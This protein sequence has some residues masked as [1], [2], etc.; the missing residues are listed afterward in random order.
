M[1]T[2]VWGGI[3][4]ATD[5]SFGC[6]GNI[7][8][9][10]FNECCGVNECKQTAAQLC[11]NSRWNVSILHWQKHLKQPGTQ[12]S[13]HYCKNPTVCNRRQ[14]S[15]KLI[16]TFYGWVFRCYTVIVSFLCCV[17]DVTH[18]AAEGQLWP[19]AK[20]R[21]V[22]QLRVCSDEQQTQWKGHY[23]IRAGNFLQLLKPAWGDEHVHDG[24]S[25]TRSTLQKE[26]ITST[27][28]LLSVSHIFFFLS[29]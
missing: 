19:R 22:V 15:K 29:V 11:G 27:S 14:V 10:S 28:D 12:A 6:F 16:F 5:L 8:V 25:A 1:W 9:S 26:K 21:A 13:E 7:L 23:I 24:C 3:N 18:T 20:V 17:Q 2:L 4:K